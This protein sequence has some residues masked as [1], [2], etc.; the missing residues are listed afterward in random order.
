MLG[1]SEETVVTAT[2]RL[3]ETFNLETLSGVEMVR[4]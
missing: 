1:G 3:I 4:K 2:F